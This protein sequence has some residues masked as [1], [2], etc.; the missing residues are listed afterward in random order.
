M[1]HARTEAL[2]GLEPLLEELRHLPGLVE[3]SRGVFYRQS[4]AFLHFHEDPSGLYADVRTGDELERF[5][6]TSAGQRR[7]LLALVRSL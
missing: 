3:R 5:P 2:D 7:R 1:R 6:V 4:R